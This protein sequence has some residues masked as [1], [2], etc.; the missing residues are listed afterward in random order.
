[1]K[2]VVMIFHFTT[3]YIY[4]EYEVQGGGLLNGLI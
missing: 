1:M 3:S 2:G 4:M